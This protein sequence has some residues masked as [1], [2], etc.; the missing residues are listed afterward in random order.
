MK[1]RAELLAQRRRRLID[2]SAAQRAYLAR[3]AQPLTHTLGSLETG[4]RIFERIR[5]HPEWLAAATIGLIAIRPHR[6]SALLQW[7]T[8]G[9]RTW[10]RLAPALQGFIARL[11]AL[12]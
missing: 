2:E 7:G 6:L 4:I 9:L 12:P 1:A 3:Q 8:S 11:N 5:Q 10:R